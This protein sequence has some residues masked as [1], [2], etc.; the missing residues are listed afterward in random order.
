MRKRKTTI[1]MTIHEAKDRVRIPYLWRL[2]GFNGEPGQ[3]SFC[4]FHENTNSPAF[5]VFDDGRAFK[6]F[7]GCGQGDAVTFI[8]RAGRLSRRDACRRL[9]ELAGG[10]TSRNREDFTPSAACRTRNPA[11]LKI[12]TTSGTPSQLA[13]FAALRNVGTLAVDMAAAR[14]LLAFGTHWGREAWFILDQSRRNAQ[15]RRM[16]G[17]PWEW[18]KDGEARTAKAITLK[19]SEAGWPIGILEAARFPSVALAEGGPDL[20][21]AHGRIWF[22]NREG[23]CA[24][25]AMLGASQSIHREA[26]QHFAGKRV[27]V[28]GHDDEAGSRAVES[29]ARQLTEAG[30]TV[31]AFN[32]A[33]LRQEDGSPVKDF[34]E[35][36]KLHPADALEVGRILP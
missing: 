3:S 7:A 26:L 15:A 24:A 9:V 28:F 16:D 23:D 25:V 10:S 17:E 22:E 5:S 2:F 34:N 27:R 11:R 30:A 32:F 14:G 20:L 13:H 12:E 18:L 29:W 8:E 35:L 31:D 4:P 19:G 1:S 21:A 33:G 6:C 36:C